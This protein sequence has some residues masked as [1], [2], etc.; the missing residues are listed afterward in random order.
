M[1]LVVSYMC[2]VQEIA[3]VERAGATVAA[4]LTHQFV[5]LK[6]CLHI[7]RYLP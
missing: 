2:F 3:G 1:L 4:F 6:I 7:I 5:D